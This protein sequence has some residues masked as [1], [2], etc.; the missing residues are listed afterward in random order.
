RRRIKIADMIRRE[1]THARRNI[2]KSFGSHAHSGEPHG[3]ANAPFAGAEKK[4]AGVAEQGI[5]DDGQADKHD[6]ECEEYDGENRAHHC[7]GEHCEGNAREAEDRSRETRCRWSAAFVSMGIWFTDYPNYLTNAPEQHC[8][9]PQ[10]LKPLNFCIFLARLKPCPDAA[11]RRLDT[12]RR[13]AGINPAPTKAKARRLKPV[14][15]ERRCV[16]I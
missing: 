9:R 3:N 10:G 1:D 16:G 15:H 6:V 5:G 14:P 11:R 7:E 12:L 8:A 4:L 2:L 13:R